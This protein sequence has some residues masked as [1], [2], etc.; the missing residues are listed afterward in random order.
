MTMLLMNIGPAP[1]EEDPAQ[2]GQSGYD[3]RSWRE[4][5]VYKRMLARQFPNP[6]EAAATLIVKSF[7]HDLGVYREVCVCYDDTNQ[8]AIDY[9]YRLEREFPAKWDD[10]ARY[11]LLWQ[12]RRKQVI[13]AIESGEIAP[14]DIPPSALSSDFPI[15]PAGKTFS[16]LLAAF[17]L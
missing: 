4:C 7:E 15:L 16:E 9:A 3:E 11:E 17:P 14:R 12:E 5:T 2:V 13:H 1:Y 8:A 10:I 6:D